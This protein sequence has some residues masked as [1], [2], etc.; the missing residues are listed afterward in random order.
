MF[1]FEAAESNAE[2]GSDLSSGMKARLMIA[3]ALLEEPHVLILDEIT[4]RLDVESETEILVRIKTEYPLLSLILI[5]HRNT[6]EK[7]CNLKIRVGE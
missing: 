7:Y 5:S 4:T 2:A 3:R 1:F 6:V